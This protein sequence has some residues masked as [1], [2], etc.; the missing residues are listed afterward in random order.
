MAREPDGHLLAVELGD[1]IT[2]LSWSPHWVRCLHPVSQELSQYPI[3]RSPP[4]LG[5][6][7]HVKAFS[8]L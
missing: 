1:W 5:P 2:G 3:K 8:L 4:T 6:C 7:L